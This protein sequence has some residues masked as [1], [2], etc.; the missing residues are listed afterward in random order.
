MFFYFSIV[1]GHLIFC[2]LIFF[3]FMRANIFSLLFCK[4]MY[5]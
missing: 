2:Y 4:I 1:T 5:V 3:F